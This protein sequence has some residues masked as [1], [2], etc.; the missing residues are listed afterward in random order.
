[1]GNK[2]TNI[3]ATPSVVPRNRLKV[4]RWDGWGYIDTSFPCD[5]NGD[6]TVTSDRYPFST[7][8]IPDEIRKFAL[9]ALNFDTFNGV[10][11]CESQPHPTTFP[12]A[13]IN[14]EFMN[15]IKKL[16]I[17]FSK[18]GPDRLF[19]GHGQGFCE[20]I[21]LRERTFGRIPDLVTWPS[22]HDDVVQLVQLASKLNVVLV[23]F[24]GGT[25]VTRALECSVD[26]KRM[27]NRVLWVDNVN[28]MACCEAGIMG[29]DLRAALKK[30]NLNMGHEPDSIEF[31][32]LG[33]WVA[34]RAS[35]MKKNQY[36]N[37][38]D[39]VV[40]VKFVT[41]SGVLEKSNLAP[42]VSCGPDLHQ[43]AL[44]SEGTLGVITEVT[45]KVRPIPEITE[46]DSFRCQPASLRLVDN[47]Q[48]KMGQMFK[49]K[50]TWF[51]SVIDS[52]KMFYVTKYKGIDLD[53]MCVAIAVF[54]GEATD[55]AISKAKLTAIASKFDGF[56][57]GSKNGERGYNLTFIIAYLR[58]VLLA[59]SVL[60][61]SIET[62][63][64]WDRVALVYRNVNT[65]VKQ[66]CEEFGI[67]HFLVSGRVTQVYDTGAC[68]Y[69]YVAYNCE[70]L[71]HVMENFEEIETAARDEILR[72]GGSLSHHHGIGKLRSNWYPSQVSPVGVAV[73]RAV[74]Q[75][76]DPNNVFASR[77]L[78][79][80]NPHDNIICNT[81]VKNG[82]LCNLK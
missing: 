48:F 40:H 52:L 37:I 71:D 16:K 10:G 64:P 81:N 82:S 32:T 20:I 69:F 11:I 59:H 58:D 53:T 3:P 35:G 13:I 2:D 77:N 17:P 72:C 79:P 62:S 47:E 43:L 26:E 76:L 75:A 39:L 21:N 14:Q 61:E 55:V 54:E 29:Q 34:T 65:V 15:E 56:S 57:G 50:L 23:P 41:P 8:H 7:A 4:L 80:H 24:G 67:K 9:N 45:F 30:H 27:I 18:E 74:K 38:E 46:F 22:C 73:Y 60:S 68:I 51:G 63:L 25:N 70:G 78:L 44:G 12:E 19:R 28:L 5:E 31:S 6:I 42:R 36:G 1:M 49:E 33:G 66:K